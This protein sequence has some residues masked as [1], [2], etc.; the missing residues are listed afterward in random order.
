MGLGKGYARE[1]LEGLLDYDE[2]LTYIGSIRPSFRINTLKIS[3]E[4]F[5]ELS[6]IEAERTPIP[7]AYTTKERVGKTL[8]YAL[9]YLHPQSLS[10][11][12]PPYALAPK[13]HSRVL[14]IS[15][16]PGSKT[17]QMAAMMNNTG[18]IVANDVKV[19]RLSA[20]VANIER[21]GVLNTVVWRKDGRKL[22]VDGYFDY[23]LV[24]V[25]C[26]SL[27][28]DVKAHQR[29]TRRRERDFARVQRAL[30]RSAYRALKEGG[31]LVYSTCTLTVWENEQVVASFLEESGAELLPIELPF[32]VRH[33]RG[34]REY[35]MEK[36]WRIYPW[37]LGSEGFFM[38]KLRKPS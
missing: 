16:A 38:A 32:H 22:G 7:L 31:V 18:E 6:T 2:L 34:L 1:A 11:M 14:D 19:E 30:L 35:G 12:L 37:H 23:A 15:A 9:G 29:F 36:A 5:W 20:L 28:S 33:E 17:T 13:P 26:S 21:L 27:G 25:P 4:E 10:S 24:D 3:E 8:E